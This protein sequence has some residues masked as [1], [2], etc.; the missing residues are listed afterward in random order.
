MNKKN[1]AF[2]KE[3]LIEIAKILSHY[4]DLNWILNFPQLIFKHGWYKD[5]VDNN[6]IK[7]IEATDK[8]VLYI[9]IPFC[10]NKCDY[11]KYYSYDIDKVGSKNY[12]SCLKKELKNIA[13][14]EKKRKILAILI[15]G[16]TPSLL[17]PQD[18]KDLMDYLRKNFILPKKGYI[19]MEVAPQDI[20][21]VMARAITE[22][23][24]GRV[25]IGVQTFN[26]KKLKIINRRFQKNIDVYNAVSN[27]RKAGL[28]NINF[29]LIYGLTPNESVKDFLNDNLQHIL[30]IHPKYVSLFPLQHYEKFP[31]SVYNFPSQNPG[32]IQKK[33]DFEFNKI[34]LK[35]HPKTDLIKTRFNEHNFPQEYSY[36]YYLREIAMED[37]FAIGS[38]GNGGSWI[39]G[40]FILRQ[41][42]NRNKELVNYMKDAKNNLIKYNYFWLSEEDSLK[43]H[44]IYRLGTLYG[45][46]ELLIR[47]KFPQSLNLFHAIID[48]INKVLYFSDGFI[49]LKNDYKKLL[50]IKTTNNHVNYF[51]FSFLYLYSESDQ[52]KFIRLFNDFTRG[53]ASELSNNL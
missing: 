31:Q 40:R 11:C 48:K 10:K 12:V 47:Q 28:D 52:K 24:V 33:I 7:R 39:D 3:N 27:F 26:E 53:K 46:D 17:A 42:K 25:C 49:F 51:L 23:G 14:I 32:I 9:H 20:S 45:L 35:N 36:Y 13:R 4:S 37:V 1:I 19:S 16:G 8:F 44:V 21:E 22:G 34:Q 2:L 15:G 30:R 38:G 29:D 6:T 50:S 43:K 18:F 5:D 41:N